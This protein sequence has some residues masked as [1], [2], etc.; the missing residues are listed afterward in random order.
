M[1]SYCGDFFFLHNFCTGN[2]DGISVFFYLDGIY[3]NVLLAI[4]IVLL[5]TKLKYYLY[6][7]ILYTPVN[8]AAL[9]Q[10]Y[11]V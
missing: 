1:S 3:L 5:S 11:V 9:P 10:L 8:G 4:I 6:L 2:C 7:N